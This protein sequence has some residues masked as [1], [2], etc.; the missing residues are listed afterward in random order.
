MGTAIVKGVTVMSC[1][2]NAETRK[3]FIRAVEPRYGNGAANVT[4]AGL[5]QV[6]KVVISCLEG[7]RFFFLLGVF[8]LVLHKCAD[9]RFSGRCDTEWKNVLLD[10]PER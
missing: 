5:G 6:Y 1:A 10:M 2:Y 4:V 9:P 8:L 7:Y 3:K